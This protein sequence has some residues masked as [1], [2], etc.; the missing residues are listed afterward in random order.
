VF[1]VI[2]GGA[3]SELALRGNRA[4]LDAVTLQSR[5]LA[6]I[7]QRS[8]ATSFLGEAFALPFGI[9]PMGTCNLAGPG[10]DMAFAMTARSRGLPMTVP[11]AASTSLEEIGRLAGERAWFPLYVGGSVDQAMGLV[12]RA[13]AAGYRNLVLTVDVPQV[14]R[15]RRDL[16]NGFQIPLRLAP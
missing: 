11:S 10:T 12:D 13:E 16:A 4:A 7:G 9:A 14:A 1:D 6:D 5:V 3:G 15:R 8:L 2:D